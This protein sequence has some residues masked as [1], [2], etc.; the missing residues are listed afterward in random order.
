MSYSNDA[1]GG[2]RITERLDLMVNPENS[3]NTA[4]LHSWNCIGRQL[5]RTFK[6]KHHQCVNTS[7][8]GQ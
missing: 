7:G 3:V 4:H 5:M 6:E 2:S 1:R 8:L